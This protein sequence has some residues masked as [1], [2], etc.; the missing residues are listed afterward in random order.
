MAPLWTSA[1]LAAATGGRPTRDFA[2]T[3]ISIDTRTL[4]PGDLFVAL[5]AARDGHDFVAEA[6][7]KGAAGALVARLPAGCA[8]TDP[9]L[10]VADV[11]TAL[12]ALGRAARARSAAKVIAVTGSAGKTSTKEMLRAMLAGQGRVHAAEA[13]YNN[14]W[15]VPLTLSRMPAETDFAVVEIGMN[16]PGEIAPLARLTRPDVALITT[17]GPAHLE[18]FGSIEGIAREKAAIFEGLGAGGVAI[19]PSGLAVSPLLAEAAARHAARCLTFGEA[20]TDDYRLAGLRLGEEVTVVQAMRPAGPVLLRVFA[21][22]RHF[23]VNAL[24]ALAAAEAAGADPAI[25]ACDL[26]KWRPPAGRGERRRVFLDIVDEALSFDVIDDAFNANPASLGAALEVLA[27]ARPRDGI[28]RF[29][30]GR[31]IAML[32]DMLELGADEVALHEAI[33]AHPAMERIDVVHC[34][35]PRMKALW[36]KLPEKR[37]GEWHQT[38]E[39]LARRAHHLADA[40]DVILVK[41]SKGSRISLVAEALSKLGQPGAGGIGEAE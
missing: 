6:L 12:E 1:A 28:G 24:G 3:G 14:H 36:Q 17:V 23:A 7:A 19:V 26:A 30:A 33:A 25:A 10:R 20:E 18:A 4:A 22:G 35:G 32:G 27:A 31:R 11:Q 8:E 37:R 39:D 38:A 29:L 34:V 13:S 15:G 41:G 2:A 40:G 9:L 21:A 16:H 5:T